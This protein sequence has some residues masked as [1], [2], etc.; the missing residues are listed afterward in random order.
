MLLRATRFAR[1]TRRLSTTVDAY[2]VGSTTHGFK[3]LR[4]EAIP[5]YSITAIQLQHEAT[6]ADYLHIDSVDSNNVFSVNF[7]TPPTSSNGIAH[8]L[9]HLVLCGSKQYPVRDPFFNMLKR[10]LNNFMNAMTGADHT[11]YPFAT[12]NRTDFDNLLRVY[13]DA[14]FF[15]R[16]RELDFL[17]EG[18]RLALDETTGQLQYKGVVFNEMKGTL[19]DS[20]TL[21]ATRLQ[22]HVMPTGSIYAH[23]SGGDPAVIPSLT[24]DELKAFHGT[25]YHPSNALFYSY[26]NFPL[27]DHLAYIN[28][29]VLS[30]F[31]AATAVKIAP[32]IVEPPLVAAP[33][34]Q[35]EGP[36][37]GVSGDAAAQTKWV[38]AHV[39]PNVL[40]TDMYTCLV[41]RIVSF[42]LLHGPSAPLYKALILSELAIDFATGTGVDTSSVNPVFGIGVEGFDKAKLP[43]I[44]AT[45]ARVLDEVDRDGFD[46]DR[47]DAMLHQIELSQ[48]HIVGK[49]GMTL[50]RG[51]ASTWCHDGDMIA[52]LGINPYLARLQR[53]MELN[54]RFLQDALR[55]YMI[56]PMQTTAP[57]QVLMEPSTDFVQKMEA[58]EAATLEAI[59]ARL[60]PDELARIQATTLELQAHQNQVPDVDCLPTLTLHDIPPQHPKLTTEMRG[61][62]IQFVPQSTNELTYFRLKFDT[63]RVPTELKPYLPFFASVLGQLGTSQLSFQDLATTVQSISG[64]VSA[65]TLLVPDT[66]TTAI[67]TES[68]LV[69]TL[70]LPHKVD[71]TLACLVA[72]FTDTQFTSP[73]NVQQLKTLL[74]S[75]A[76]AASASVASSG[77][78]LAATRAQYGLTAVSSPYEQLHGLTAIDAMQAWLKATEEDPATLLQFASALSALAQ[79]IFQSETMRLS[80]V[81]EPH[82]MTAIE[83]S[84]AGSLV[85]HLPRASE[86]APVTPVFTPTQLPEA[87]PNAFFGYPLSV[88]FNVQAIPTVPLF[89]ADHVP[90]TVLAQ[91]LSSCYLHQHVRE[92]GGAYGAGASQGEGV[93]QMSSYYDP[94]TLQTLEAYDGAATFAATG[95]FSHRDVDEALLGLFSS[96]DAPQAPSAKGK[97]LFTRG[98]THEM[99]QARRTQLLATTKDDIVRVAQ[100]YLASPATMQRVIVGKDDGRDALRSAGF[101]CN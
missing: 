56:A 8:I 43:E 36:D 66:H 77:H 33:L 82:L 20:D 70:C 45:I 2:N 17:Q 3:V 71:A 18:H 93:F 32:S 97:G 16:L 30:Q 79:H 87:T 95:A 85:A 31:E 29:N 81:T 23:V 75:A 98:F 39:L 38:Q 88:N 24:H 67:Y 91:V 101:T 90:L 5:E 35:L 65:S 55:T 53:D 46:V 57:I 80:V 42:L 48:K 64:G 83:A 21:F 74:T 1:A 94:H 99:L 59:Q 25:H 7:R 13:L 92:K 4:K 69:E 34:V 52:A 22:Q 37:D 28:N 51:A 100:T 12:T 11:M 41:L 86:V 89:H 62:N 6:K 44:Q 14:T 60:S 26:G 72:V 78:Q 73:E 40:S 63:S 68:L 15:P 19:S 96:I 54:P 49:F 76:S 27:S 58:N 10:S 50:L 84:I 61:A 9:E 47:I